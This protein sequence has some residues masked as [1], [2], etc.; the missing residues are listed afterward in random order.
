MSS[1]SVE[2]VV[3]ISAAGSSQSSWHGRSLPIPLSVVKDADSPIPYE[4]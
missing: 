3:S 1:T 4:L 2:Y